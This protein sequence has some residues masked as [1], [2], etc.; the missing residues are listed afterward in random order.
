M[1][2]IRNFLLLPWIA[3]NTEFIIFKVVSVFLYLNKESD[4]TGH[5]QHK[6]FDVNRS[7]SEHSVIGDSEDVSSVWSDT[8]RRRVFCISV[9]YVIGNFI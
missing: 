7:Q 1:L 5:H 4:F 2:G 3:P 6:N 8:G 9:L